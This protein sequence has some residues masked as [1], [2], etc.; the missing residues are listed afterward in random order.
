M[1]FE[2]CELE[3]HYMRK[4]I[5]AA[6]IAVLAGASQ[7]AAEGT[8]SKVAL[9]QC[10]RTLG[11]CYEN[12]KARGTAPLSCNRQCTTDKCPLPWTETYGAFLDRRIEDLASPRRRTEFAGLTKLKNTQK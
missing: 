4:L 5:A 6:S 8:I 11:Q 3:E 2:H 12:C 7:A 10:E 1:R 9:D